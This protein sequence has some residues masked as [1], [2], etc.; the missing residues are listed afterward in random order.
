MRLR[1]GQAGPGWQ[2]C[3]AILGSLAFVAG[4]MAQG[5]LGPPSIFSP[6]APARSTFGTSQL[7]TAPSEAT[8]PVPF[9]TQNPLQWGP[10]GLHPHLLYRFS[11]GN[12][13]QSRPGLSS[14]TAIHELDPGLLLQLGKHWNLDYTPTLKFYSSPLFRDTTDHS[15]ALNGGTTYGDWSLG[16]SQRYGTSSQP[17]VE[18]GTQTSQTT[19]ATRLN[20]GCHLGSKLSL[21]L[22]VNQSFNSVGQGLATQQLNNSRQWSTMNWLNYQFWPRFGAAVGVGGGYEQLSAGSSMLNE[23]LQGR[24]NWRAG[25]KLSLVL[26]G[27]LE[28]R[29]FLDSGASGALNPVFGLTLQYQ[30]FEHTA[31]SLSATR[32][33]NS[34]LFQ[35][36]LTETTE[37]NGSLSQRLFGRLSLGLNGG[38]G[39]TSYGA[40]TTG[41]AVSREDQHYQAGV[42]LSMTFL[43]RGTAA[44]F[45]NVSRNSSDQTVFQQSIRQAGVEINYR[46]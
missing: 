14:D 8:T 22:G 16:L 1:K 35:N 7:A 12:G 44:V 15:V 5:A 30:F 27:G 21:E 26:H 18:T 28:D 32:S 38:Y 42:R 36:Q 9:A 41:L 24:I 29:Q 37:F 3:P 31:L 10:V 45:Y 4:A 17:L 39:M 34:S 33:V 23:Q 13:L 40:T 11:Y 20:A 6:T 2:R 43:K 46:F 19:Y 25:T